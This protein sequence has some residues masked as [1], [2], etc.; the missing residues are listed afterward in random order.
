[1]DLEQ[2]RVR[3]RSVKGR[4]EDYFRHIAGSSDAICRLPAARASD[5]NRSVTKTAPAFIDFCVNAVDW[6]R[7]GLIGFSVV[8]QQLLASIALAQAP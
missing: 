4:D 5:L 1:M 8:F 6:S 3:R 7:F 2:S